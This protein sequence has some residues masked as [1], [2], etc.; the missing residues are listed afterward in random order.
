MK[1]LQKLHRNKSRTRTRTRAPRSSRTF[2]SGSY[3]ISIDTMII[4]ENDVLDVDEEHDD[5]YDDHGRITP[6]IERKEVYDTECESEEE[7]TCTTEEDTECDDQTDNT[8][9]T[10]MVTQAVQHG[11]M[12]GL[13]LDAY[14]SKEMYT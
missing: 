7:Q 1:T 12:E 14:D 11:G 2:S 6:R 3:D 5:P 13:H 10:I 9:Y 4:K 8:K